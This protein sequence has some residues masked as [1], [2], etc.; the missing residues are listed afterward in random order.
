MSLFGLP[1]RIGKQVSFEPNSGCWIWTGRPGVDGYGVVRRSARGPGRAAHRVVY[2]L[3]V[4]PI[5]DGLTLDHLCRT[6]C[7][8][9]PAH[10][11]PV[12]IRE[13]ILRGTCP[14]A[15]NA[16]K[17]HCPKGHPLSGDNLHIK[18]C[19]SGDRRVCR[20]CRLADKRRRYDLIRKRPRAAA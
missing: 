17:T 15:I 18:R 14:S 12:T 1:T 8:V 6:P 16:K 13:N 9:N 20:A 11:E 10:L 4:S 3:L 19:A 7:C 5:P 2:E